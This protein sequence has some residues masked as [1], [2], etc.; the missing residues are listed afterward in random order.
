MNYS[1]FSTNDKVFLFMIYI[2]IRVIKKLLLRYI[3]ETKPPEQS[4]TFEKIIDWLPNSRHSS[5]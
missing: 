4:F 2:D 1:L 3:Q 5:S